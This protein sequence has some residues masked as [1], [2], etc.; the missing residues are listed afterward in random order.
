MAEKTR[1]G[2]LGP[3]GIARRFADAV[4]NVPHATLMAVGSRTQERAESFGKEFDI[5]NRHGS[6]EALAQDPE[7]D[8]I[9]VSTPHPMHK[10]AVLLAF[11][12]RKAVLCEKPLTVT[13]SETNTLIAAAREQ[14][15]FL[16]EAMWTRFL[17]SITKVRELI[18]DNAIGEV[19]MVKADFGFRA[20]FDPKGRLF[21][22][23]LAGG[24]LLD[25]GVYNVSFA[26]MLLGEPEEV[27][28]AA[29]LGETG[30][31]EQCSLVL[32]YAQGELAVLNSAV[33]TTM[34]NDAWVFGTEGRIYID[35]PWYGGTYFSLMR[36]GKDAERFEE[37]IQGNGF[38]YQIHE[39]RKCLDAGRLES[40]ILPLDESAAVMRTMDRARAQWGLRYPVE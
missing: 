15:C 9:Y 39:V 27:T 7:V 6:Y 28:S 13:E 2:I 10:D 16:M 19:R 40:A 25:V 26:S 8:A 30:V 12:G 20:G 18:A 31:D 35:A 14:N 33:R 5:P 21:A 11:E 1:W 4:G 3:G 37:P 29:Q 23:E 34:S 38:E 32:K 17:P 24:G 22:P 36:D